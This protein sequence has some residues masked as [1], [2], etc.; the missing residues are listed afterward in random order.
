MSPLGKGEMALKRV[1]F[2][3]ICDDRV[4]GSAELGQTVRMCRLIFFYTLR[5]KY[6]HR[7]ERKGKG[8]LS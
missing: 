2:K 6:I 4:A 3:E 7:C 1:S 8:N 5:K